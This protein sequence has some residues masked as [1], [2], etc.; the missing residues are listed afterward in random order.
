MSCGVRI[1]HLDEVGVPLQDEM[2][3][4]NGSVFRFRRLRFRVRASHLDEVGVP[5]E[6]E[7]GILEVE[8][9]G[10]HVLP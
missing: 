10:P 6:D 4:W 7:R 1:S 2:S 9:V 3:F 5:R 8:A